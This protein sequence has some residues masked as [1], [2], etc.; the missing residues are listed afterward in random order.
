MCSNFRLIKMLKKKKSDHN[1]KKC[2]HLFS[3]AKKMLPKFRD[4]KMGKKNLS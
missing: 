1:L 3:D 4:I 2:Y